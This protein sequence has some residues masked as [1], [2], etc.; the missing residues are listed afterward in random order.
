MLVGVEP[1]DWI[2]VPTGDLKGEENEEARGR[3]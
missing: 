3:V 1:L 2:G